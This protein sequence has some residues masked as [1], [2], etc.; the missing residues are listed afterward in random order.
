MKSYEITLP[1]YRVSEFGF[2]VGGP[3]LARQMQ[4]AFALLNRK[5]STP[6]DADAA[7]CKRELGD[8]PRRERGPICATEVDIDPN[9]SPL[10]WDDIAPAVGEMVRSIEGTLGRLVPVES[11]GREA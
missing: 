1:Q 5:R 8:V 6:D 11:L 2:R 4:D 9:A 7:W 3:D 10:A